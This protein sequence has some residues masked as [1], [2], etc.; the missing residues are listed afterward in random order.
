MR[1][2]SRSYLRF[3][4]FT[5]LVLTLLLIVARG[6]AWME[7]ISSTVF[8]CFFLISFLVVLLAFITSDAYKWY[9]LLFFALVLVLGLLF[10]R[11]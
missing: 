7:P 6:R 5:I 4:G 8:S 9:A 11:L 2:Y 1:L 10:P 3:S